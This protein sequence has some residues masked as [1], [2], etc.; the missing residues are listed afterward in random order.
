VQRLRQRVVWSVIALVILAM[1]IWAYMP[2][3]VEVEIATVDRGPLQV[4]VDEDGKTRIKDKYIVSAPL[5]GRLLR[6]ELEPGDPVTAGESLLATI[7]PRDPELLD[8]RA[9]AEARARLH[10]AEAALSQAAPRLEATEALRDLAQREF[11][12]LNTL[13]S[14]TVSIK[15][16]DDA[17]TLL[18]Q[19]KQEYRA[20]EFDV[21]I[22]RF[23]KAQ[24]EAALLQVQ[25]EAAAEDVGRFTI[26]SPTT[27]RVLRVMQESSAVVSAGTPLLE[28]GDPTDLEIVADL[29]STDAVKV[30][31]GDAVI[32][33]RWGGD[34]E[35]RGV[36]RLVEPSGFTKVSALGVEEQRVNVVIDLVDPPEKRAAL[37]D[38]FRVEVRIVIW[39]NNHVLRVPASALFRSGDDWAVFTVTHGRATLR[40]ITLG[41]RTDLTAQVL[42]G[43]SVGDH[44]IRH[45]GDQ[46]AKG[47]SVVGRNDP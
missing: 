7:R 46:I 39:Q 31:P 26:R 24:A 37:G 45:P 27:G 42:Q 38:N 15:E 35:L 19:R 1:M 41:R 6:I 29:L 2:A 44:V 13:T 47:V 8:A 4:T 20:A 36:V 23:E 14:E 32:I 28:I 10:A 40:P 12:R 21:E 17:E 43:L 9:L 5:A 30:E 25:G 16:L 18:R 22:A 34:D 11:D 3:P 33:E